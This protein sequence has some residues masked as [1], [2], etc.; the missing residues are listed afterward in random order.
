ML[1]EEE[2]GYSLMFD[3]DEFRKG[4][5]EDVPNQFFC[6]ELRKPITSKYQ[7]YH[8]FIPVEEY[9]NFF[10][11]CFTREEAQSL[12]DQASIIDRTQQARIFQFLTTGTFEP[13][14]HKPFQNC[15]VST[16]K[17]LRRGLHFLNSKLE[18]YEKHHM[19]YHHPNTQG[20]GML[21]CFN[22]C[23]YFGSETVRE[24]ILRHKPKQTVPKGRFRSS[25][26][27]DD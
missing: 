6:D 11:P 26:E 27:D 25:S 15:I 1:R 22:N 8:Q 12:V 5:R 16:S 9:Q 24:I 4:S 17:I 3:T 23:R 18:L 7:A 21:K 2:H 20:L 10:I 19:E 13:L 14:H